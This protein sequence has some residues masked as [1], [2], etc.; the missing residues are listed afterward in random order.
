MRQ[1][2][3]TGLRLL[4]DGADPSDLRL[5]NNALKELRHAFR[6]FSPYLHHRKVAVFGSARTEKGSPDWEQARVFAEKIVA[7][8]W[9]VITGAGSGIMA[10]AQGGAGREAS[11]GVNIRLPFEQQA[12]KVIRDDPKL[13]NFKYFF[14]RKLIFV[15]ESDAVVLLP[16]GFGTHDEGFETLTLVQTG[17]TDPMPLVLLDHP[18]SDY[19]HEWKKYVAAHLLGRGLIS[20][21]DLS[22]YTIT[23][24]IEDACREI[25][26]Q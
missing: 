7:A 13:V 4:H 24:S 5:T 3:V 16:G 11:F 20:E 10:A 6:V 1:I 2:L 25:L 19:W 26:L 17:K 18:G 15:K 12:N 9:M 22:L 14:T 21:E 23:D 8:G